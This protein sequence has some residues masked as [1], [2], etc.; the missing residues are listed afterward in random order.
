MH[1]LTNKIW[2]SDFVVEGDKGIFDKIITDWLKEKEKEIDAYAYAKG[3]VKGFQARKILRIE[4]ESLEPQLGC[5]T[6]RQLLSELKARI[7]VDG[8]LDYRTIDNDE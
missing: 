1:E 6:T 3:P 2:N 5:A 7:D 8:K 4:E